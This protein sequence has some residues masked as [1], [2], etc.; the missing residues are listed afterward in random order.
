MRFGSSDIPQIK[1]IF[2]RFHWI[3]IAEYAATAAS[4]LGTVVTIAGQNIAYATAP[5][6]LAIALNLTNRQRLAQKQEQEHLILKTH[7]NHCYEDI[8][9]KLPI[10][11]PSSEVNLSKIQEQIN[12]LQDSLN[13]LENKS[14]SIATKVYQN[15]SVELDAIRQEVAKLNEPFELSNVENEIAILYEQMATLASQS[16][17]DVQEYEQFY[18][19]FKRLEQKTRE[20]ILP[21]LRV[22]VNEFKELQKKHLKYSIKLEKLN[23]EFISRPEGAQLSKVKRV[24]SQ[25]TESVTQLQQTEVIADLF[26]SVDQIQAELKILRNKFNQRS[27][28]E[29]IQKLELIVTMLV[30]S[31]TELKSLTEDEE[32]IHLVNELE[33]YRNYQLKNS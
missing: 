26:K 25:L 20:V 9:G 18:Q 19:N 33:N 22:M 4:A 2:T 23:N 3:E 6:S 31:V 8:S 17:V 32:T 12:D 28:P 14:A 27:E 7:I 29:Q 1:T 15:L 24:V 5:L 21:C 11:T 10:S 13:I 16:F 30:N